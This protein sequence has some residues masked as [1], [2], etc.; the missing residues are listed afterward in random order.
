MRIAIL[1]AT[2]EIAKDLILSFSDNSDSTLFLFAR[3]P[4]MVKSW[5][6]SKEM[7]NHHSAHHFDDFQMNQEFDAVLNFVGVGNP[8]LAA[9]MGPSIFDVTYQFDI[10]VLNYLQKYPTCRY[11]FMSS[12]AVYGGDFKDPVQE[13]S[14]SSFPINQL[15]QQHWYG[16]AKLYAEALHRSSSSP[17]VDVRIFNYFS[18]TQDLEANFFIT[19]VI[20]AIV[21]KKVLVTSSEN[22]VRDYLGS[23]D[24]FSLIK[25]ILEASPFNGAI[26][27]YSASPVDKT[28]ILTEFKELFGLRYEI[29]AKVVGINGTGPKAR[30]YSIN[31]A[32]GAYGYTP[33]FSSIDLLIQDTKKLL[34]LSGDY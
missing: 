29:A 28:T 19:E 18:H 32:A 22:I 16:L 8:A 2:S 34:A 33:K 11:I 20:R 3:R 13:G 6:V 5:L 4:E 21:N 10:M 15:T 25:T 12:G 24:F 27:C 14:C 23:Q 1:G 17:I 9:K 31:K 7:S 30:Y 26:D